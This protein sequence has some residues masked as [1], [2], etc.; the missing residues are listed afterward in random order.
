MSSKILTV[1]ISGATG[2]IG[3]ALAV[4]YSRVGSE[5]ILIGKNKLTLESLHNE[6]IA[7][8]AK[9]SSYSVDLTSIQNTLELAEHIACQYDV[10][11]VIS[12]AGVTNSVNADREIENWNDIEALLTVNL[13]GA[14]AITHPILEKMQVNKKGHVAYVS[15]IAAY[16]GMPITPSYCASK[17]GLKAYSEAM[18]GLLAKDS[19]CVS[20]IAPGFVKTS[21]S[22]KFPGAKPLM[23]DTQS[24]AIKIKKGLDQKK[25]V[26]TFPFFLSLGMRLLSVIPA[27]LADRILTVL[28][29]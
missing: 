21:M 3:R 18:R 8:G 5:L 10:D 12:N 14:I 11:L 23:L 28:K 7:L 17:A 13:T 29:Y 2:G 1:V 22:D 25:K 20:L 15:S 4:E 24:A 19:I 16:Y 26:I 9:V 27:S 6:C